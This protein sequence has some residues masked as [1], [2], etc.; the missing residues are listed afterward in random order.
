MY[1]I[2]GWGVEGTKKAILKTLKK[3]EEMS[4][5]FSEIKANTD[6]QTIQAQID[7]LKLLGIIKVVKQEKNPLTGSP[8]TSVKLTGYGKGLV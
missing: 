3:E 6:S 8:S 5:K 4:L 2:W 1:I 7:E